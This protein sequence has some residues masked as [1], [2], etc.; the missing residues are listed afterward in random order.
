MVHLK[1][2]KGDGSGSDSAAAGF[3]R[4]RDARELT[5]DVIRSVAGVAGLQR[6]FAQLQASTGNT[7]PFACYEWQ[8]CIRDRIPERASWLTQLLGGRIHP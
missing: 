2:D 3:S 8:M 6:D 7:L 5:V 4:A 1:S